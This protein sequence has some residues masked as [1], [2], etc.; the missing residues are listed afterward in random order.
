MKTL[1][2]LVE[3]RGLTELSLAAALEKEAG[4][5]SA[6]A[7]RRWML[8]EFRPSAMYLQALARVL[9]EEV[10]VVLE[11]CNASVEARKAVA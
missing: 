7:V 2:E 9:G 11:A 8:G 10:G 4:T 3:G 5:A 6:A 1:R